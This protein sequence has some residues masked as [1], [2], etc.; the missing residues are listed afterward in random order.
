[1]ICPINTYV[2]FKVQQE[3]LYPSCATSGCFFFL[4]TETYLM[5]QKMLC[6]SEHLSF[7]NTQ[8]IQKLRLNELL[9]LLVPIQ[10]HETPPALMV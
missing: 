8:T 2:K 5:I 7:K 6:F 3:T 4:R 1:M 10:S 9:V